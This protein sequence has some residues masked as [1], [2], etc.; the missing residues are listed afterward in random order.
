MTQPPA[1][2]GW[3][4]HADRGGTFTDFLALDPEGRMHTHKLLSQAPGHYADAIIAGIRDLTTPSDGVPGKAG[5]VSELRLGTTITTNALLEN[6]HA[7]CALLTNSGFEDLLAIGDQSRPKLFEL[8]IPARRQLCTRVIGTSARRDAH[9]VIM[10]PLDLPTVD[11]ALRG[12]L[13]DGIDS[14][15]IALIHAVAAPQDEQAIA[16]HARALGFHTVCCSHEVSAEPGLLARA[17]TAVVE[18]A[19]MPVLDRYLHALRE[20]L[21][22][23]RIRFMQSDGT[24]SD[25]A[26]L[27]ARNSIFSGPAGGVIG[28]LGA[29]QAFGVE[30]VIGLDMG[31]TSTDVFAA[32]G[33]PLQRSETDIAGLQIRAPALDLHT[34]AAGGGSVVSHDGARMQ[35]GPASAGA[36]PGPACYGRGG[37]P[38]VTDANLLLGRLYAPGFAPIFGASGDQPLDAAAAKAAF[39]TLSGGDGADQTADQAAGQERYIAHARGALR[40]AIEHMAN[41]VRRITVARG[42]DPR[43][44]AL[45]AFGGA[46]AQHACDIAEA[47][48]M[49]DVII[50]QHASLLS[51]AGMALASIGASL[52][53]A[54]DA[55]LDA[56][57]L[58]R[59]STIA[60]K[61]QDR[62]GELLRLQDTSAATITTLL[63]LHY[64]DSD[65]VIA[66]PPD[67]LEQLQEA[68]SRAHTARF[69]F[70]DPTR[71]LRI[72]A[73]VVRATDA[74]EALPAGPGAITTRRIA[75]QQVIELADGSARTVPVVEVGSDPVDGP[76]I[77]V[78]ARSSLWL[79]SGWC[80][81]ADAHGLRLRKDAAHTPDRAA[82]SETHAQSIELELFNN[83]FMAIAEEMGD[84]LR[85]SAQ[86]V[87][88]RNRLDYSCALFNADGALVANAPH[89]P[90]HLGSM[91]A[92]VRCVKSQAGT[93]LRPGD[94]WLINDPYSGGTHLP[95]LTVVM[96][97]F[98]DE[99]GTIGAFVAARAHHADIGGRTPGS[100]PAD[101]R[102]IDDEGIRITG[103]HI[104]SGNTL[105]TV[106]VRGLLTQSSMPARDPDANVAD[107]RAQL[108]ACTRGADL[109]S[110]LAASH[111][112]D[113]L[114]QHMS[115]L[116][117]YTRDAV[118]AFLRRVQ[119]TGHRVAM[120]DGPVVDVQLSV[121]GARLIVNCQGS[122]DADDGNA[123]APLPV[124]RAAVMYALRCAM[125]T[126]LPLNDGFLEAVELRVRG[127]SLLSP[128]YPM[129]VVAG[130]VETSQAIS[131]A[132]LVALGAMAESQ[133]T[134]NN[135]SFG[136][137]S[138]Q[139]YETLAGGAGAGPGFVGADAVHTHMTNS[140]ITDAEIMERRLPV[141]V[142]EF[143]IRR[144]SGG[145]GRHRGGD[146]VIRSLR[147]LEPVSLAL[148]GNRRIRGA[149]GVAGG[150]DGAP[151]SNRLIHPEGRIQTVPGRYACKVTAGTVLH[152]ATPG[153]GGWGLAP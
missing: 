128:E 88:V 96:P 22:G 143:A 53:E 114:R 113:C 18:A 105:D 64:R 76:A 37:P 81:I 129:A 9:G 134:M 4:I 48:G 63:R 59:A 138:F 107:L 135:C 10:E 62:A 73:V 144:S 7:R 21:P 2:R 12:L 33:A 49:R 39:D 70:S 40:I 146:G 42:L 131:D 115:A 3:R 26:K 29:A 35:V 140:R 78:L 87:N 126:P 127:P 86:S 25:I 61:L 97:V 30:Q 71:E 139:Y 152:V 106:A 1:Q 149:R 94:A 117:I 16:D 17:Q 65:T 123:N 132:L 14:L 98:F 80:A 90:V 116:L 38:T 112:G 69:G 24:L 84:A 43:R 153:G 124:V 122:S 56:T 41:A 11:A 75:T 45:V 28:A 147:F 109:L 121:Q 66:L 108:A 148:I 8:E 47:I 50:P 120:D 82:P 102:H 145:A 104:A 125:A 111:G 72:A 137:A 6:R 100:M 27:R 23:T 103:A 133:G 151:G 34:V 68:F 119:P 95:D 74:P 31:G 79:P 93:N 99:A 136:N 150:S 36:D 46:G 57:A 77:V 58:D 32:S 52:E 85:N 130:N 110:R 92:S 54:I 142:L 20:A 19:L 83:R 13:D 51:A 118:A 15:A 67:A 5:R 141:H 89:I 101:S 55:P 91:G 44:H 60:R